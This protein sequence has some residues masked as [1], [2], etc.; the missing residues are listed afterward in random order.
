V[1]MKLDIGS[2]SIGFPSE[3]FQGKYSVGPAKEI[4]GVTGTALRRQAL[5]V[6][7]SYKEKLFSLSGFEHNKF[8][9]GYPFISK[10]DL[11]IAGVSFS[12]T[13]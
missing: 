2:S 11:K 6:M 7:V 9:L 10:F 13:E 12:A 1:M 3:V 5:D 4:I 8:L